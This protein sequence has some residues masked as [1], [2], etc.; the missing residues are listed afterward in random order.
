[1]K[2]SPIYPKYETTDYEGDGFDSHVVDFSQVIFL[3]FFFLLD[4]L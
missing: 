3:T 2:K 4:Y 1:M